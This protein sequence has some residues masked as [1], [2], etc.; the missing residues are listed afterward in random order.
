[1]TI[2]K[3]EN[4]KDYLSTVF[5][6]DKKE[7]FNNVRINEINIQNN[8][9]T[10]NY[11]NNYLMFLTK[12]VD[13]LNK[14]LKGMYEGDYDQDFNFWL[15]N[16]LYLDPK[17]KYNSIDDIIK[18]INEGMLNV[19][20]SNDIILNESYVFNYIPVNRHGIRS[21]DYYYKGYT[22][23]KY[24]LKCL[25]KYIPPN[26]QINKNYITTSNYLI[27]KYINI[28]TGTEYVE[29][30]ILFPIKVNLNYNVFYNDGFYCIT[31]KLKSYGIKYPSSDEFLIKENILLLSPLYN[32][33][34]TKRVFC[35]CG[36]TY[37]SDQKYASKYIHIETLSSDYSFV[38][39]N[40]NDFDTF[41]YKSFFELNKEEI[42]KDENG[43]YLEM[44]TLIKGEIILIKFEDDKI[45][46][47]D[48]ISISLIND[49]LKLLK[50]FIY[51]DYITFLNNVRFYF[52]EYYICKFCNKIHKNCNYN[53]NDE[54][55]FLVFDIEEDT[56]LK[57]VE[58]D[59][60][61]KIN[62]NNNRVEILLKNCVS[63]QEINSFDYL[64][65]F[66]TIKLEQQYIV[67]NKFKINY[68]LN[69]N[70]IFEYS[71]IKLYCPENK[72]N[73]KLDESKIQVQELI[74]TGYNI[75]DASID[76][77]LTKNKEINIINNDN[78]STITEK[79]FQIK[80]EKVLFNLYINKTYK[81]NYCDLIIDYKQNYDIEVED[82]YF[83]NP[84]FYL[85]NCIE[86]NLLNQQLFFSIFNEQYFIQLLDNYNYEFVSNIIPVESSELD[87]SINIQKNYID[88]LQNELVMLTNV[89]IKKEK[90]N[91][92]EI[93]DSNLL[94]YRSDYTK[95]TKFYSLFNKSKKDI[96]SKLGIKKSKLIQKE[97]EYYKYFNFYFSQSIYINDL[98][99]N[100]NIIYNDYSTFSYIYP[101]IN[102]NHLLMTNTNISEILNDSI[103]NECKLLSSKLK[104]EILIKKEDFKLQ[105]DG[106]YISKRTFSRTTM[107]LLNFKKELLLKYS[108]SSNIERIIN[109]NINEEEISKLNINLISSIIENYTN[110][111]LKFNNLTFNLNNHKKPFY[112]YIDSNDHYPFITG[113]NAI[114][115]LEYY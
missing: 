49:N 70:Y 79:N 106:I 51:E 11:L 23:N 74:I 76:L 55:K 107:I 33:M 42:L 16:T 113:T 35:N 104:K 71:P 63:K 61:R 46:I 32:R 45:T 7:G 86:N 36:L 10:I 112:I 96:F 85:Y 84:S 58:E 78:K 110:I 101:V 56:H 77:N 80:L 114:I 64:P 75:T 21:Y 97:N 15:L 12:A 90:E 29:N 95:V 115:E 2:Y 111:N 94:K 59:T 34:T 92:L 105:T 5:K 109:H 6:I 9:S 40:I 18:E 19:L 72:K 28:Y 100:E 98:Y 1:M 24:Y 88:C 30:Y 67:D 66:N 82:T 60:K 17:K 20:K 52:P 31:G 103:V 38:Y 99:Y 65:F 102:Y 69:T 13:Y 91:K 22:I 50:T 83:D 4:E 8:Y 41:I 93:C 44:S 54:I 25:Y 89:F 57:K 47:K 43:Y 14:P 39:I 108:Y 26:E 48:Q 53:M 81:Y 68:H 27:Y 62:L 87:K 3:Q 37:A 73:Y